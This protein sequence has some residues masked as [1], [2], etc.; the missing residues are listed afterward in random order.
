MV[1]GAFQ[2][3]CICEIRVIRNKI[4]FSTTIRHGPT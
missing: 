2:H 3:F 1:F 4:E